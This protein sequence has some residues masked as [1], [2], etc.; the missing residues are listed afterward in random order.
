MNSRVIKFLTTVIFFYLFWYLIY[1]FWI[2]EHTYLDYYLTVSETYVSQQVFQLL[3]FDASFEPL[4]ERCQLFFGSKHLLNVGH[5][6]NALEVFVIFTGFVV[7]FPSSLKSKVL[8]IPMGILIIYML[9]ILR[10]LLLTLM[11]HYT[12][13]YIDFNHKYT[14]NIIIHGVVFFLWH[15]WSKHYS[16]V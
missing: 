3:G 12:P 7:C 5:E 6:C 9:N 13:E 15:Y 4:R 16:K 8:F 11:A 14:F 2:K 1:N 10:I